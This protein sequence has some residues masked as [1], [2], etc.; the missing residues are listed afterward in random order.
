LAFSRE[1]SRD[2]HTVENKGEGLHNS[3]SRVWYNTM[4]EERYYEQLIY[5]LKTSAARFYEHLAESWLR[6]GYENKI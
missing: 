3:W 5:G 6:L 2:S 4:W 1:N